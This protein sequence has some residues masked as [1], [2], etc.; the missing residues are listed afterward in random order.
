MVTGVS[1]GIIYYLDLHYWVR[2]SY[3]VLR[4]VEI[5]RDLQLF[6]RCYKL[7]YQSDTPFD[8]YNFG[9]PSQL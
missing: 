2:A 9:N 3:W 6:Y 7:K 4:M 5:Q 1:A 8:I